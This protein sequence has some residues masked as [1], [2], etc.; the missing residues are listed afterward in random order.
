V[1]ANCAK[2]V[3]CDLSRSTGKERDAET[4][5]DYFG[6]RYY[7]SNMGRWLSPDWSATPEPVPYAD[8]TDPQTLN[9]YGYVRNNPLR[10]ADLD[11]HCDD[12]NQVCNVV[13]GGGEI[14]VGFA[15]AVGGAASSEVGV[16]IPVALGGAALMGKGALDL[17]KGIDPTV[18]TK[19]AA[20]GLKVATGKGG[21]PDAV[22]IVGTAATG[23]IQKG[24]KAAETADKVTD[25]AKA[26]RDAARDP[27]K[28]GDA[29]KKVDSAA[30]ALRPLVD[31]AKSYTTVPPPPKPPS[32]PPPP[33]CTADGKCT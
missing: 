32:P 12:A 24:A 27:S 33:K 31:K 5:L 26:V 22:G 10:R 18:D 3:S 15:L 8:L 25:A 14:V 1:Q 2:L 30:Q 16:G 11:G 13:K 19:D 20:A 23:D 9:L 6:A 4:G 17:G 28:V 7:G 21:L 29:A